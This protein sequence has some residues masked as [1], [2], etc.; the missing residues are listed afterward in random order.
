MVFHIPQDYW[1]NFTQLLPIPLQSGSLDRLL[2]S[3]GSALTK[4]QFTLHPKDFWRWN[5]LAL[6]F[7]CGSFNQ[8]MSTVYSGA[9]FDCYVQGVWI[10]ITVSLYTNILNV[11]FFLIQITCFFFRGGVCILLTNRLSCH[12]SMMKYQMCKHQ[13]LPSAYSCHVPQMSVA[14]LLFNKFLL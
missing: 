2:P 5:H 3:Y 4:S 10:S 7:F 13:L 1:R 11:N 12:N 14:Q 6:S 8:G 9:T